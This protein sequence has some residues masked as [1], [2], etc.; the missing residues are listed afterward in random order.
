MAEEKEKILKEYQEKQKKKKEK[1]DKEKSKDAEKDKDKDKEDDKKDEKK[2][3]EDK[4]KEVSCLSI[5]VARTV[6]P[7][8]SSDPGG[9]KCN[10]HGR[11][12]SSIRAQEVG[13]PIPQTHLSS[14]IVDSSS[15]FYQQRLLKKRQAESVK[16]DRER[17]S[18]PG[19]F[20]SVPTDLPGKRP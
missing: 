19:Y 10:S 5:S 17:A 11:R 16:R 15:A 8:T 18:Q 6:S 14:M 1:E 4:P 7:L 9:G 2:A 20:P 3:D 13:T 12:A